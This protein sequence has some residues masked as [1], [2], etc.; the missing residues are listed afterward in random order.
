MGDKQTPPFSVGSTVIN[1]TKAFVLSEAQATL[2]NKGLSFIPTFTLG[3]DSKKQLQLD[4][5]NYHR[6]LKL[7][8]FFQDKSGS[9]PPFTGPSLWTPPPEAVPSPVCRLIELDNWTLKSHYKSTT[10]LPNLSSSETLAISQLQ[11]NR[12]I[13]IKPADKG[14]AVVIMDREQYVLEAERQLTDPHY[15][16][17][18][19]HPIYLDTIKLVKDILDSLL[20]NKFINYK[21]HRFLIGQ[22]EPKPRRFYILPKIHKDPSTW[23]VPFLIPP[24]RPIVSDCGSETYLTAEYLDSFLNPLSISHPSYIKDTYHFISIVRTLKVPPHCLLFSL[25]VK[26][27]YTNIPITEGIQCIKN[28]FDRFPDPTRPDQHLLQLLDLNLT[29]NDFEFDNKF[30]L[31]IKGTA[32]GKK[33]APA[34]ANIYMAHWEEGVLPKCN[35]RPSQF[36][37]YLDDIWGIWPGSEAE[38]TVFMSVLNAHNPSIQLT[39]TLSNSTID[40]L[41]TTVYKGP[42]FNL[43]S[44][45]EIKVFFKPTDTH[46]LL[47]KNS[48]HPRHTFKGIVKSQL[49]IRFD[50]ICTRREDFRKS[51]HARCVHRCVHPIY[52]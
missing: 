35:P 50:R 47:F 38:F 36:Y 26:N 14:S 37:R 48:F 17:K 15:Y 29:R 16:L 46:A 1:L 8:S 3:R 51:L 44:L 25:D 10:E 41:D 49:R 5:S 2:L 9:K 39:H 23:T 20:R 7:I 6:R 24:G 12:N 11:K 19:D 27:L 30:Y 32:M 31:Q 21:Q 42:D 40:F 33:F 22:E 13:V 18:L 4:I 34:Y 52:P 43:T 45:F 28:Q